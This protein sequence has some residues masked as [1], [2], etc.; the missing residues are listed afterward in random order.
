VA[1]HLSIGVAILFFIMLRLIWRLAFPVPPLATIP[2]WQQWLARTTHW[3][4]YLLVLAMSVLGWAAASYRGWDVNL[5]GIVTMPALA[6]KGTKWA[7]TAGDIHNKLVYVLLGFIGLHV[8][9]AL[10]H[11]FIKRDRVL[12][13]MIPDVLHSRLG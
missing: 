5:F 11:Y 13:R 6:A 7:H 8:I 9:G 2:I 1:W 12:Q 3:I 10:Y 4:L